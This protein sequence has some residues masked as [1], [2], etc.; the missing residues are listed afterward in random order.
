MR[1]I[2]LIRL[3]FTC[4]TRATFRPFFEKIEGSDRGEKRTLM[5]T[6]AHTVLYELWYAI[7]EDIFER[8]CEATELSAEQREALKSVVLRPNDFQIYVES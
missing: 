5:S 7:A 2:R 1:L 8:V 4:I 6:V 3:P